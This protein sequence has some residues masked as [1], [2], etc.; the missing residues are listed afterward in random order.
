VTKVG[1]FVRFRAPLHWQLYF[2]THNPDGEVI[3]GID[4]LSIQNTVALDWETFI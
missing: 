4:V 1:V 2:S 3:Y